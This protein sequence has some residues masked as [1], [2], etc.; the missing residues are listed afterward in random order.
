MICHNFK[1]YDSY[2]I[3]QYLHDNAI[4]PEVVTNGSKFM[5]IQVPVCKMRFIDSL[6][7]IPMP[8]SDMPKAF[9]ETEIAKG[10][11]PHFLQQE[12]K[13]NRNSFPFTRH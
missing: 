11:F 5:T 9:G 10:Y 12:R 3:L 6:N 13:S 4:L 2:P 8:L 1:G 7:F